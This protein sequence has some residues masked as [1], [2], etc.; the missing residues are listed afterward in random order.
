MKNTAN[1]TVLR[2]ALLADFEVHHQNQARD[3]FR[4][5]ERI[6]TNLVIPA[7]GQQH[8]VSK[9]LYAHMENV[10]LGSQNFCWQHRHWGYSYS[11]A[12]VGGAQ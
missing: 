10:R 8:P 6:I 12:V 9:S 7:L 11:A 2:P 1:K 4:K 5:L 3:E